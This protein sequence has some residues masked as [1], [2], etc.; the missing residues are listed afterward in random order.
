[1]WKPWQWSRTSNEQAVANARAASVQCS[2]RRVESAEVDL[3]LRQ[4]VGPTAAR[5]RPGLAPR[6]IQPETAV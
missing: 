2:R 6:S 4:L 1:M 3:F 5:T